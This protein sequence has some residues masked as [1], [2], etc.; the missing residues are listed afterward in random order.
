MVKTLPAGMQTDLDA[1]AT[2]HCLCWKLTRIDT[3]VMGFTDHDNDVV[4]DSVTFAAATGLNAS[5][6]SN[7][8]NL[9]VDDMDTIG[10][11]T[12]ASITE[13]DIQKKL[14]DDAF[15]QVY[16]VD[17][18]N[19]TKRVEIFTGFLGN[20]Q[21][22][23]IDFKAEVRSLSTVLNQ[24]QGQVYQKT[25]NVDLFSAKCG[26]L[27]SDDPDFEK[28]GVAV[29]AVH[30]RRLFTVTAAAI[31]GQ[32]TDWFTGGKLTWTSGTNSGFISEVKSS[33]LQVGGSEAW[34]DLWEAMPNDIDVADE[35]TITTGCN[36]S[37]EICKSKFDNVVNFRGFPR[38]PGTDAVIT[39]ASRK[40]K[41]DGTSWYQ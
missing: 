6:I 38:I 3:T 26:V 24:G 18:T 13:A 15:I 14:Y 41:N 11:L 5:A 22:G 32:P 12:A 33:L 2:M 30:S 39:Y 40:D 35:F 34:I 4:F 19:V 29:A 23:T 37:I 17:F 1:G 25:C 9:N 8:T 27:T 36:K 31:T 20:V 21:R 28:G 7:T 16:R 10:A